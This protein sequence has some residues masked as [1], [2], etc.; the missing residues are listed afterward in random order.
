MAE[1][2]VSNERKRELEQLDPFQ[3]TLIKALAF[4]KKYK[5]QLLLSAGAVAVVIV[6][7]SGVLYSF[8]KSENSASALVGMAVEKYGNQSDPVKAYDEVKNDFQQ[9]FSEYAN[10]SAGRQA[11]I[12]FAGMAYRASKYDESLKY[13]KK[14]LEAFK[15]QAL[16]NNFL[17]SSL[18]HVCIAK[19]DYE[20]AEKY[21]ERIEKG[22]SDLLKDE[23][24]FAIAMI[25][26]SRGSRDK[27]LKMYGRLL[28]EYET[29]IYSM[30][31]GAKVN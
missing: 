15:D 5:N 30:I 16:M 9:V 11:L 14:A 24:V 26:E 20:Q 8:K 12:Q 25:N 7:F 21:F 23:A 13:Y 19:K 17:L 22:S 29:S 18:G 6:V 28:K 2:R 3:E 10:T 31:A 4:T 27:S 1:Q